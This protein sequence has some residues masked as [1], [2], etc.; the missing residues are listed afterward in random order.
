MSFTLHPQL[1]ADTFAVTDW[2]LSTVRL[3]NDSRYPWLILV[4]R[5]DG[6]TGLHQL[7]ESDRA[8]MMTE[9]ARAS[10]ALEAQYDPE[11]INVAALGNMVPQL[12]VHAIARQTDDA[13]WPGPVWGKGA[14]EAYSD[15]ALKTVLAGL[16]EALA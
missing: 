14:A 11:R 6:L 1:E 15:D 12:H 13:A 9:I 5:Q 7:P 2:P 4:P 8:A 16:R 10:E 3:M